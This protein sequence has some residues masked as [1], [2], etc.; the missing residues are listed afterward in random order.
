[1]NDPSTHPYRDRRLRRRVHGQRKPW[2]APA[3]GLPR[4]TRR[5]S[6]H[7]CAAATSAV[8]ITLTDAPVPSYSS[9]ACARIAGG[10]RLAI[11]RWPA[12]RPDASRQVTG[13]D[14]DRGAAVRC[15]QRCP[16]KCGPRGL[17]RTRRRPPA[18]EHG[19][20]F[21]DRFSPPSIIVIASCSATTWRSGERSTPPPSP[22]PG[23]IRCSQPPSAA[24]AASGG[25]EPWVR[26]LVP[27]P[28]RAPRQ[29][30]QGRVR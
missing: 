8:I 15:V 6:T 26:R 3:A 23:S 18:A 5:R 13:H 27:W 11:S 9:K 14:R 2:P 1:M 7:P 28:T 22:T 17:P 30:S 4:A 16:D 19:S 21:A 20:A 10:R 12:T 29:W 25:R 24:L